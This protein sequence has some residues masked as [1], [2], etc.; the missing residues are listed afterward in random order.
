VSLLVLTL[1]GWVAVTP[2]ALANTAA[3]APWRVQANSACHAFFETT[4]AKQAQLASQGQAA[5]FSTDPAVRGQF[6]DSLTELA[7]ASL[8]TDRRLARVH[9]PARLTR[10]YRHMIKVDRKADGRLPLLA[11]GLIRAPI[12]P[13]RTPRSAC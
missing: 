4:A 11:A 5:F 3:D 1:I 13:R 7:H 2:T 9:P 12:T 8:R 10:R 6:A